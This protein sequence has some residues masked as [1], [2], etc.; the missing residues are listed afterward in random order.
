M[1]DGGEI[2][3]ASGSRAAAARLGLAGASEDLV[4]RLQGAGR[5]QG[6]VRTPAGDLATEASAIGG[7]ASATH[8]FGDGEVGL[9]FARDGGTYDL[10]LGATGGAADPRLERDVDD[11]RLQGHGRLDVA[12][13]RSA[14]AHSG[15]AAA[16]MRTRRTSPVRRSRSG[17]M[18]RSRS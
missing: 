15:S 7:H 9:R 17:T 12:G 5:H 6:D 1:R 14:L 2:A 8:T 11:V 13:Q 18:P 4:W 16:S 10:P 3:G